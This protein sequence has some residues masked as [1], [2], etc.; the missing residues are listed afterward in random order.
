[1]KSAKDQPAPPGSAPDAKDE[2]KSLPM[3]ELQK[4]LRASLDGL[5]QTEA[6]NRLEQYGPNE[7]AE[8]PS[9]PRARIAK[10]AYELYEQRGRQEGQAI[11]DWAKA[12]REFSRKPP[13]RG[14]S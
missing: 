12:E 9:D 4:R 11:Q 5:S 10:R 13:E 6:Q 2:L 3:L 14:E 1:M 8:R 7:I